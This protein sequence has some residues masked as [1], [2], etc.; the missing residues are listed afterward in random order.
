MSKNTK[1]NVVFDANKQ[2][3][4]RPPY[5]AALGIASWAFMTVVFILVI[6]VLIG[7]LM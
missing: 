7:M 5:W 3:N 6:V 1:N 2:R 4:N